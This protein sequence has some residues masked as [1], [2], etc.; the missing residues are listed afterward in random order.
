MLILILIFYCYSF[1]VTVTT[2]FALTCPTSLPVSYTCGSTTATSS[3]QSSVNG[4]IGTVNPI[5][6]VSNPAGVTFSGT[7]NTG[8][9]T[10]FFPTS[11]NSYQI[12]GTVTDSTGNSTP[13]TFTATLTPS[14]K[15]LKSLSNI[16]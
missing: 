2:A 11:V 3:I 14:G 4:G 15:I 9:T 5:T 10:A 8:L 1:A 6:W 7:S 12:F 13:C 16:L